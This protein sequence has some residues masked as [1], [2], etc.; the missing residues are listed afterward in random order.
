MRL[1]DTITV[2]EAH[3]YKDAYNTMVYVWNGPLVPAANGGPFPPG[4]KVEVS[5]PAYVSTVQTSAKTSGTNLY[6]V[7][8]LRAIIEAWPAVLT[9]LPVSD[10]P[11]RFRVIWQGKRC[12]FASEPLR[13]L[14]NGKTHHWTLKL[15]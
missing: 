4:P 11:T 3:V 7:E 5:V 2:Q 13:R 6:F 14:Q 15:A 8:D 1:R 9:P 10:S 12:V